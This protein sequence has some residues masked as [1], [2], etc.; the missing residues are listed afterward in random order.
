MTFRILIADDHGVIRAGLHALLDAESD[1][2]VIGEAEDTEEVIRLAGELSP[3]IVLM[4]VSMPGE[5]GIEATRKICSDHPKL[6]VLILT[7]H[8]DKGL[9][10]E[11]L[12]YGASGYILKQ[13]VKSELINAI[14][15]VGRGELYIHSAL[16][17]ALLDQVPDLQVPRPDN[18]LTA[19][20]VD[21]LRLIA[22]GHTNSQ[23]GQLL[24]ISIRTVEFHRSNLITK[25]GVE[26]RVG[27]VRYAEEHG[28]T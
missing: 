24:N 2:E 26:S 25:L 21:V 17:R 10:Q 22:K 16:T 9:L 1:I 14:H 20:E 23:I 3:D 19:R 7:V 13:A 15:A 27:L 12:R 8:E 28:L 11:A 18:T 6:R 5:G 4:D